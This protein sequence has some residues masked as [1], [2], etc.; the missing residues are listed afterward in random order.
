MRRAPLLPVCRVALAL[1]LAVSLPQPACTQPPP[2][3]PPENPFA[4]PI[5]RYQYARDRNYDVRHMRVVLQV[6]PA[7]RTFQGSVTHFLAALREDLRDIVLDA[8]SNLKI[9]SCRLNGVECRFTHAEDR[10]TVISPLPLARGREARLEIFYEHPPQ[11]SSSRG[12]GPN[13]R[14]GWHWITPDPDR[15]ERVPGFWTQGQTDGNHFWVPCYDYPN[16]LCTSETVVTVPESYTV[17]GNGR[18]G[19]VTHN[20]KQRTRTYRWIMDRPHA[21]YLLSLVGGEMDVKRTLWRGIPLIYTV[22]KGQGHLIEP[23]FA[24]TPNILAFF[25]EKLGV[26]YPYA[27][28]A[29][30]AVLDFGGGMENVSASTLGADS[31]TDA[32]APAAMSALNAHELAHQWFGDMVTCRDWG[33]L[34]LNEGFATFFQQLYTEHTRGPGAHDLERHASLQDYLMEANTRYRRPLS[35]RLYADPDRMFDAH[36]YSRG[37]LVLHMLRR[38]L[39][40]SDFFGA[41]GHYLRTNAFQPVTSWDL[42]KAIEQYTGRN[43]E[44][45][46]EQWV[47]RP[48]HPRLQFQWEYDEKDRTVRVAVQQ[49]QDA[50]T[51]V[52]VYRLPLTIALIR[53]VPT[54]AVERYRFTMDQ[55]RQEFRIASLNRPDAVLIDPDHD[56]LKE[57][58]HAPADAE[59]PVLLLRAP[60]PIDRQ[61]AAQRLGQAGM[62]SARVDLFLKAL[63]QEKE[64]AVAAT[65]LRLL[66]DSR[67]EA[68]RAAL[69]E[70]VKAAQPERRAAALTALGAL[71]PQRA[72][73][74]LLKQFAESDTE[75]YVVV[76]AALRALAKLDPITHLDVFRHQ[77]RA[78]T[79]RDRLAKVALQALAETRQEAVLPVLQEA[80]RP[81]L[82]VPVRQAAAQALA[83]I[84]PDNPSPREALLAL[85]EEDRY[86]E[87]Q[88]A[89]LRALMARKDREALPVL[90]RVATEA[91]ASGVRAL[92]QEAI[93]ALQ[94]P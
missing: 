85:L 13:G 12:Q 92:A 21:T 26:K 63:R 55:A 83:Q 15:P 35:T 54:N 4:A 72:D 76:E 23:S 68:T 67:S 61:D 56:L 78:R 91:R 57:L 18:E 73:L 60:S 90:R 62:D 79:L 88:E 40:D 2:P 86:P 82:S 46:F 28:Y 89:A 44:E 64:P 71:P 27:K 39:G 8:G 38:Q 17:I 52:P 31:L 74:A 20:P 94:M 43:V 53:N 19:K 58:D 1:F 66:G 50:T 45:F 33:D 22:P 9:L 87:L 69:R 59:L 14:E 81:P 47:F 30:N 36:S 65:L 80:T 34:W 70:E 49:V 32:R 6:H 93:N 3:G 42:S 41:L 25:S 29:Q 11:D 77:I 48:G 7:Q 51:G 24:D 84:A 16:D 5:A 37:A 75:P 10:L